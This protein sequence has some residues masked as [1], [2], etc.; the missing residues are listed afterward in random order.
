MVFWGK[1]F[2]VL[3]QLWLCVI[4]LAIVGNLDNYFEY[5]A[6]LNQFD[7]RRLANDA[8]GVAT[9]FRPDEIAIQNRAWVGIQLGILAIAIAIL[10]IRYLDVTGPV[11]KLGRSPIHELT[12]LELEELAENAKSDPSISKTRDIWRLVRYPA[13][14]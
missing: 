3:R 9:I 4:W 2:I 14:R 1:P 10:A 8:N 13:R 5:T 11:R 7:T 12:L 6:T